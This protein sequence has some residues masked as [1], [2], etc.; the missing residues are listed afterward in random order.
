MGITEWYPATG[1][2]AKMSWRRMAVGFGAD[3]ARE[4]NLTWCYGTTPTCGT[5]VSR[6]T[7]VHT[8]GALTASPLYLKAT[9][10]QHWF[11]EKGQHELSPC[12]LE[13]LKS[14][15]HHRQ[16]RYCSCSHATG[17]NMRLCC[18]GECKSINFRKPIREWIQIK[19]KLHR[20]SLLKVLLLKALRVGAYAF[21]AHL[22]SSLR[23][24]QEG[25]SSQTFPPFILLIYVCLHLK[26]YSNK[27]IAF[28]PPIVRFVLATELQRSVYKD[29]SE[30]CNYTSVFIKESFE[31]N[32]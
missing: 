19:A 10:Q 15:W 16:E 27:V 2:W 17:C 4:W 12:S 24:L 5:L 9:F 6:G 26:S 23:T 1:C 3:S 14:P 30:Y 8:G 20:L 31:E 7:P 11:G 22:T 32:F 18:H 29:S 13:L 25:T 21:R 28:I